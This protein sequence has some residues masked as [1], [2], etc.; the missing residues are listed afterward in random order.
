MQNFG[1]IQQPVFQF[2]GQN[3]VQQGPFHPSTLYYHE[4]QSIMQLLVAKDVLPAYKQIKTIRCFEDVCKFLLF[5]FMQLFIPK[6]NG[7]D[8]SYG[9]QSS[10]NEVN[11]QISH[12]LSNASC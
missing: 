11:S 9:E 4:L 8:D 3:K 12:T 2:V 10:V 1:Q 7:Q 6:G 5:P